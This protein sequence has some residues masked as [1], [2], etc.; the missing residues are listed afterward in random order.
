VITGVDIDA[1]YIR[2][3]TGGNLDT[4]PRPPFQKDPTHRRFGYV[5]DAQRLPFPND[6]FDLVRAIGFFH[7]LNDSAS[8]AALLEMYRCLKPGKRIVIFDAVWPRSNWCRPLAW[9]TFSLDRG[10]HIRREAD[11][12]R[13]LTEILPGPWSFQRITYTYT[14]MECLVAVFNKSRNKARTKR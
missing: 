1:G 4:D 6:V 13:F 7:H 11:F 14:G 5:A 8:R 10:A 12:R 9:A 3:Y 2:S